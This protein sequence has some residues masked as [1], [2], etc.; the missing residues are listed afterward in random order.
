MWRLPSFYYKRA[1][2]KQHLKR[3]GLPLTCLDLEKRKHKVP[4]MPTVRDGGVLVDR[5]P[6]PSIFRGLSKSR[7]KIALFGVQVLSTIGVSKS[8]FMN[9]EFLSN[10]G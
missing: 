6:P 9:S 8:E 4:R 1:F 2:D 10:F 3:P 7:K 5:S